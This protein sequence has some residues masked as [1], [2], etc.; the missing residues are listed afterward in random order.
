MKVNPYLNPQIILTKDDI[1]RTNGFIKKHTICADSHTHHF[2]FLTIPGKGK[3]LICGECVNNSRKHISFKSNEFDALME[4][5][6]EHKCKKA[7]AFVSNNETCKVY[8]TE[9]GETQ[10]LRDDFDRK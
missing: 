7:F 5:V 8:C 6:S 2:E 9:C 4:F 10:E 3:V 1:A